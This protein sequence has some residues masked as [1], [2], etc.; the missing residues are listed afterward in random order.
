MTAWEF[1]QNF[2]LKIVL[3]RTSTILYML[4]LVQFSTRNIKKILTPSFLIAVKWL[5]GH[6]KVVFRVLQIPLRKLRYLYW[7]RSYSP[8]NQGYVKHFGSKMF[9]FSEIFLIFWSPKTPQKCFLDVLFWW[10][11][12]IPQGGA[13]PANPPGGV[14]AVTILQGGVRGV[15]PAGRGLTPQ[16]PPLADV[17][18]DYGEHNV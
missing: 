15:N 9:W 1:F 7:L 17:W 2:G 12:Q 13:G 18:W 4:I 16:T 6:W 3:V 14:R 11:W 10:Q 8:H 5:I